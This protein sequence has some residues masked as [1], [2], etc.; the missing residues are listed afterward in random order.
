M[1]RKIV[2]ILMLF[3]LPV[4]VQAQ[5]KTPKAPSRKEQEKKAAKMEENG[6]KADK[7]AKKEYA[8]RQSKETKKVSKANR[9]KSKRNR[10][11]KGAPFWEKWFRKR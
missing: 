6:L 1:F 10:T 3:V 4:F 2:V 9:K 8:K 7:K 11:S 5:K